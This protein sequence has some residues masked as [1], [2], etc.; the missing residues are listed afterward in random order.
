MRVNKKNTIYLVA[1]KKE[2]E[3]ACAHVGI[4]VKDGTDILDSFF[5]TLRKFLSDPR[6]PIIKLGVFGTFQTKYT[7]IIKIINRAIRSYKI[8]PTQESYSIFL[9]V[10]IK[11]WLIRRRIFLAR[12]RKSDGID[13]EKIDTNTFFTDEGKRLLGEDKFLE[14]FNEDGKRK[15][16]RKK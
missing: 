13:W 3:Q 12:L 15:S 5:I 16:W 10:F 8:N 9:E 7:T 4:D 1:V 2:L 14:Y 11:L 6:L